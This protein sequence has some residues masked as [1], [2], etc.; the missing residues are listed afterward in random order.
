MGQLNDLSGRF[1]VAITNHM[2]ELLKGMGVVHGA[3]A[4][5]LATLP[6]RFWTSTAR[7]PRPSAKTCRPNSL[8]H[9]SPGG[10]I[11]WIDKR[12]DSGQSKEEW[13]GQAEVNKI[14][15]NTDVIPVDGLCVRIGAMP[16][17]QPG[18][19]HPAEERPAASRD[20]DTDPVR[21]RVGEVGA[22]RA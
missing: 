3:V 16:L 11:P 12:L 9:R 1:R 17:P 10:L 8:A 15:G 19:D 4:D 6:L 13:K 2:R 20:R 5:E 22:E 21:Q 14:L 18:A 7:W